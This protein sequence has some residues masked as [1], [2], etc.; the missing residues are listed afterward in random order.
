MN[1]SQLP[2]AVRATAAA[3]AVFMSFTMLN[4]V[5]SIAEPEQSQLMA[6]SAPRQVAQVAAAPQDAVL[7]AQ[8]P[9]GATHR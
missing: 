3:L 8:G 7:V 4:G 2:I 6:R 1:P 9:T 5:I